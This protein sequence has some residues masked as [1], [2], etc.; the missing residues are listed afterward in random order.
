MKLIK[1]LIGPAIILTMFTIVVFNFAQEQSSDSRAKNAEEFDGVAVAVPDEYESKN[2]TSVEI[3]KTAPDFT[4][5]TMEGEQVKLS[6]FYGEKVMLNFWAS[7][8]K[9]CRKEMPEMQKFH[10][11]YGDKMNIIA[12]N[13]TGY[14]TTEDNVQD[15]INKYNLTFPVPLDQELTV[16]MDQYQVFNLPSSYFINTEGKVMEK[17]SGSITFEVLKEK[18]TNLQ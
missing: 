5:H 2:Q 12:V 6:D 17:Y 16:S 10:E 13:A 14:E 3:G 4:L 15:F 11:K 7:W 9:P 1:R 8:C 18:M